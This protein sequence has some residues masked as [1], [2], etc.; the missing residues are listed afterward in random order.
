MITKIY[1]D[2]T[3]AGKI[4]GQANAKYATGHPLSN[5]AKF[6]Q[7][8]PSNDGWSSPLATP[9]RTLRRRGAVVV[10]TTTPVKLV[11]GWVYTVLFN[12]NAQ[13]NVVYAGESQVIL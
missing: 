9:A 4:F 13:E 7:N 5:V 11:S 2:T 1:E 3:R 10:F 6:F 12:L 8:G